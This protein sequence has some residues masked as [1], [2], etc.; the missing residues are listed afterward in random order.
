MK[1]IVVSKIS[2]EALKLLNQA[3]YDVILEQK[4]LKANNPKIPYV[5]LEL[6]P[7]KYQV[8]YQ[9]ELKRERQRGCLRKHASK[10]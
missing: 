1:Q 6:K 4:T 2:I 8:T 9:E 3:G 7:K 5:K 10:D